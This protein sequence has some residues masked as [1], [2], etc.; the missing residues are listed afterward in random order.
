MDS[1]TTTPLPTR[2][3]GRTDMAITRVG[4]GAWAIG[5]PDWAVGWG[6]QDDRDSVAAIRHAVSRG[7]NWIDTA[8]V[9]GLGHS[10]EVVGEA[11]AG[12][13]ASERPYVFTKGGLVWDEADRQAMPRRVGAAASLRREVDASLRRLGVERIDLYQ[14][15]WPANDGTAL[16]DYWGTLLALKQEGKLRAVGLSNH[17]AAQLEAA[18]RVGHVDTLQPPF[19]AIRRDVAAAELPWCEAHGTGVIVYSP[20]QAGLLTGRFSAARA[21]ALPADDWRSRSPEFLGEKLTRNLALAEALRPIA[22]RH[23]ATVPAVAVAWT[24]AW[25]AV[26]GAI[27][28]ARSAAQVDGWIGAATLTL[29]RQ[30]LE[31]ISAAIT[32]TGAG[33]GP[34]LPNT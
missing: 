10:E 27:V 34:S 13:P 17:D 28:G 30:D 20:M 2:R 7:I 32:A 11:L 14:M 1:S 33:S 6:S 5:G 23:G 3:F 31:E 16:E 4:F 21:Q 25:P 12:I 9:Y 18:E 29:T 24:L 22:Q 19:S 8:A 15:H 26:S